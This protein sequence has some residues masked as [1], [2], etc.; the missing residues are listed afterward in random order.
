MR[1]FVVVAFIFFALN[2][3]LS[4]SNFI[5]VSSG[6]WNSASTWD[7]N[8]VPGSGDE[9]TVLHAV[10]LD[11]D[12]PDLDKLDIALNGTLI[13]D[14]HVHIENHK[15]LIVNGFMEV[16]SLLLENKA[17]AT[18]NGTLI[19]NGLFDAHITDLVGTGTV[20]ADSYD[21]HP[22]GSIFG[23]SP[24]FS[25][26]ETFG[27]GT[28]TGATDNDWFSSDNWASDVIPDDTYSVVIKNVSNYPVLSSAFVATAKSIK[29]ELG[30]SVTLQAGAQL[31]VEGALVNESG[32]SGLI[33]QSDQTGSGSL[34]FASGTPDATVQRYVESAGWHQVAAITAPS[35]SNDF[36]IDGIDS[37][38]ATHTESTNDWNYIT[39][40]DQTLN[41]NQGYIYWIDGGIAHTVEFS[42]ALISDDQNPNLE[43]TGDEG[44]QGWNLLGNPYTSAI[45][46]DLGA[47]GTNTE[48][49]VYVWDDDYN[50]VGDYRYWNGSVG[51]LT[52]GIIPVGQAFFVKSTSAGS[53]TIPAAARVHNMQEFY[54]SAEEELTQTIRIQ[55]EGENVGNTVFIG[56]PEYGTDEF[57]IHGDAAK[58]YSSTDKP[59]LFVVENDQKLCINTNAPLTSEGKIVPLHITQ[60]I[61]GEYTLT[62]SQ[63]DQLP[64][65]NITLEDLKTG[66]TQ[67]LNDNPVYT[68]NADAGDVA[69]RFRLHFELS[70]VGLEEN[71]EGD[72]DVNIYSYDKVITVQALGSQVSQNAR[73]YVYDLMGREIANQP[74]EYYGSTKLTVNLS[75]AYAVVRVIID[76]SVKTEKVFI[77]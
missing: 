76:G 61:D 53:F 39:N 47:W 74:L 18:V 71:D 46:W 65:A 35:I 20:T 24:P 3:S 38:L 64:K 14:F 17:A 51:D 55:L 57:D 15:T 58:L 75:N 9:V 11:T 33:I 1:H 16:G 28:W 23:V 73:V 10:I 22:N 50:G 40:L 70:T 52:D 68:F 60:V 31:E 29:I 59:Q 66:I 25:D 54:K 32:I 6:N 49:T 26:A 8:D 62:F 7:Q 30:A 77:K 56:F 12:T 43:F 21:F 34:I 27:G 5:S 44:D 13:G 41:R 37:W 63:L 36:Y 42:G 19:V 4:A 69:E 45:D 67:N 48:G 72:T 2:A